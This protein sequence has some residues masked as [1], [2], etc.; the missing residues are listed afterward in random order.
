[1]KLILIG[2]ITFAAVLLHAQT[3]ELGLPQQPAPPPPTGKLAP[4]P[5]YRDPPFD[6]PTDPVLCFNAEAGKWYM[7]YTARRAT[8]TNAPG[9]MWVHGSNI[10]MAESAD[11]GAT[12]TYLGTANI[13]YG[14]DQHPDDYTYWAP[15][16]I[17]VNGTYHMFV[18]FVPGIFNDWNHPR[19]IVHLTSKDGINWRT[20]GKVDLK[21]DRTIDA[22]VM[23]VPGGIW[24]MWYKDERARRTLSYADS[25]DLMSWEAKGNCVTN[26]NGEGPKVFHWKGRYW[27]VADCWRNGMR[28]WNSD[29][30]LNWTMQDAT[31]PGNHGDVV[32]SSGRAWW[33]Y[34]GG[35]SRRTAIN[36]VE[37]SV[38]DGELIA[39]DP[40][41]PTYI[42]LKSEREEER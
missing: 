13:S 12:W 18:T 32:V 20:L 25:P 6:A 26:F 36:V 2:I 40:K 31:L 4:R 30:C 5:L 38:A 3:Q 9:V 35:G 8:A 19:E 15:E 39:G 11:G 23:Q 7:Y 41:L 27:L 22:C 28:V 16:V 34:F 14:K 17:W 10:G 1:M 37:L 24:R 42:N 33:F 29:D 21:S